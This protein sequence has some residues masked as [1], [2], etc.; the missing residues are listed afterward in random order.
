[1][2]E[3]PKVAAEA[4]SATDGQIVVVGAVRAP[5][6]DSAPPAAPSSASDVALA[7]PHAERVFL[8][9]DAL[10][11]WRLCDLVTHEILELRPSEW[12]LVFDDDG[13]GALVGGGKC[14]GT[15]HEA[16]LVEDRMKFEVFH[17]EVGEVYLGSTSERARD[18]LSLR[19]FE[20]KHM[21]ADVTLRLGN[22]SAQSSVTAFVFK[23]ARG[24]G[25]KVFWGVF[26]LYGI[27][28]LKC[29]KGQRS[30]WYFSCSGRWQK[31][32]K[33]HFGQGLFVGSR[34][35]GGRQSGA[36]ASHGGFA[37]RCLSQLAG[38]TVALL[39][40]LGRWSFATEERGG[41]RDD[42]ARSA[43][44]SSLAAFL[45]LVASAGPVTIIISCS[46]QWRCRW[47]RTSLPPDV[48]VFTTSFMQDGTLCLGA[49]HQLDGGL[50]R[51]RTAQKWHRALF[52][53]T[54]QHDAAE[55]REPLLDLMRRFQCATLPAF[56]AQVIFAIARR[57][58]HIVHGQRGDEDRQTPVKLHIRDR[59]IRT[60]DPQLDSKLVGYIQ[61]CILESKKHSVVF[62]AT[63]KANPCAGS[64]QNTTLT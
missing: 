26:D 22:T 64:F 3:P 39:S 8:D 20:R 5:G 11:T 14:D 32:M 21:E 18:L 54:R 40:L 24:A 4:G 45:A 59:K 44:S 13:R 63:D 15:D 60:D 38:C 36:S 28:G 58:D 19:E 47:P 31:F 48:P 7:T 41:L 56:W 37:A 30:K 29:F 25:G 51:C 55:T 46:E 12:Q 16:Q 57:V 34:H 33:A 17:S 61:A 43:A 1:M 9:K 52:D 53:R 35:A 62:V 23:R 49:L 50:S 6:S 27:L 42:V 10:G 2:A